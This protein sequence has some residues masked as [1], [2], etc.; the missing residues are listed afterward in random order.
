MVAAAL[1]LAGAPISLGILL[2]LLGT[3]AIFVLL[4]RYYAKIGLKA[5][6]PLQGPS[7]S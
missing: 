4:R 2:S 7:G 1:L 6:P 5:L 3:T